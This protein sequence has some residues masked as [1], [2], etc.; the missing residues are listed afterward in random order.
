MVGQN[1][2]RCDR[3]MVEISFDTDPETH[4]VTVYHFYCRFPDC[5]HTWSE[6]R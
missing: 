3:F 4:D 1:C 2:P 5:Q 6:L